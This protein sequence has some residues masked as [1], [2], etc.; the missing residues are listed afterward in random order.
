MASG[1]KRVKI[2]L[3]K[4]IGK[5][6]YVGYSVVI[7]NILKRILSLSGNVL[8]ITYLRHLSYT[9]AVLIVHNTYDINN[10]L[11]IFNR[12]IK[13]RVFLLDII[14]I[15]FVSSFCNMYYARYTN[16]LYRNR[17]Q[18]ME[19]DRKEKN[20]FQEMKKFHFVEINIIIKVINF[21]R[22]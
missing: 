22:Y 17:L 19:Y 21:L 4:I 10:R 1:I 7:N 13:N 20:I 3:K 15:D 2:N 14:A 11:L 8:Y 12:L 5:W 16:I 6:N 9:I 18:F